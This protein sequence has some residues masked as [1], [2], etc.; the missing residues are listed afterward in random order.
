MKHNSNIDSIARSHAVYQTTDSL[1]LHAGERDWQYSDS[2][3]KSFINRLSEQD[4]RLYP[5]VDRARQKLSS[6]LNTSIDNLTIAE[7]SDRIL[8]NIFECFALPGTRV[9]S[10]SPSFPMYKIYS[11]LYGADYYEVPYVDHTFPYAEFCNSINETVNL[12]V[13]SNPCS[14]VGDQLSFEQIAEVH[15]LCKMHDCLLV[16]DEAYMEFSHGKSAASLIEF[17]N[18]IVV[19]TF[20]KAQG[21][22]GIRLGYGLSDRYIAGLL[23]SVRA[24]NELSAPA[25]VWMETLIDNY[26]EVVKYVNNVKKN[27]QILEQWLSSK[28][29]EYIPSNTNFLNIQLDNPLPD[30]VVKRSPLFDDV[31]WTRVCVPGNDMHFQKLINAL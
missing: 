12:V 22:A 25:I 23:S 14:P 26:D 20:S 13:I 2:I 19:S 15:R 6:F 4:I 10:V 9:L 16:V 17:G 7:G 18:I 3:W 1:R 11:Q 21:S 5:N 24:M 28:S 30:V 31:V 27:R 8:K 29:L